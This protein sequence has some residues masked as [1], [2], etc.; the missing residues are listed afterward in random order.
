MVK[1]LTPESVISRIYSIVRGV[2]SMRYVVSEA[3]F[4]AFRNRRMDLL[5]QMLADRRTPSIILDMMKADGLKDPVKKARWIRQLRAWFSIPQEV[6][7]EDIAASLQEDYDRNNPI[8]RK[9]NLIDFSSEKT[10]KEQL[11]DNKILPQ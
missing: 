5:K 7:D 2:V 1:S 3:G 8:K 6:A 9:S 10:L 11:K 4:Q